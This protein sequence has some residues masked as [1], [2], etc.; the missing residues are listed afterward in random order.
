ML[1]GSLPDSLLTLVKNK[2][3]SLMIKLCHFIMFVTA[4]EKIVDSAVASLEFCLSKSNSDGWQSRE[5]KIE[6]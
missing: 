1:E 2:E 3:A 5:K 4:H 6:K